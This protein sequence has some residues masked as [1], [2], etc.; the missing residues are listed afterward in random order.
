MVTASSL[1]PVL[2]IGGCGG[3]GNAI[4]KQLLE[5]NY[6]TDV[7]VFDVQINVNQHAGAKYVQGSLCSQEDVRGVVQKV[8]PRV[9][10]HTAS[11]KLM[12]FQDVKLFDGVN[13]EGTRLLLN[14]LYELPSPKVLVY[15]SS[16]SVVHDNRTD[17]VNARE[18][19]PLCFEPD[20]IEHYTHTKAV[21]ETIILDSNR[22]HGL[23]TAAIRACI[24]FGEGDI[25]TTP[26]ILQNAKAGRT[27][28]QIGDGTNLCDF[29]YMGN[30]AYAHILAA[31]A[32][33]R[34]TAQDSQSPADDAKKV[35]GEAFV[36][37]NDDAWPFWDF[38]RAMGA[39]AGYPVHREDVW[40]IPAALYYAIA[41]CMEWSVWVFSLGRRESQMNRK[42]VRYLTMTRT[43]DITKAKERLGYR[44]QVS[45]QEGIERAVKWYVDHSREE[46]KVV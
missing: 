28:F 2:V 39:V 9:T 31:Q 6:A 19:L 30:A 26:P 45:M 24:L 15:T 25:T 22:R 20:Q 8:K 44:P 18:D 41:V 43:F 4:V 7:T 23:L 32:L 12:G 42:M 1:D 17:L 3:L 11:P 34:E 35:N 16:S 38:P 36:I 13:I 29:T 10:I 33:V 21:A 37:T 46:K 5:K 27:K 14:A 40:Q